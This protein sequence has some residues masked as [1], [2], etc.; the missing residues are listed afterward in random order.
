MKTFLFFLIIILA[1]NIFSQ[2]KK[3]ETGL[4]LVEPNAVCSGQDNNQSFIFNSDTLC[5]NQNPIITVKDI[6]TCIVDS[7]DIERKEG[8]SLNIKLKDNAAVMFKE[9]TAKNVGKRLAFVIDSKVVMA[10][11]LRYP[12]TTGRMTIGG[13]KGTE[14]R[15][16]GIILKNEMGKQ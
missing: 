16:M 13:E 7:I 6:D 11:V 4:Y 3:I 9:Y 1:V 8:Y 12:I 5:L 14:I 10:P 2:G 15:Y